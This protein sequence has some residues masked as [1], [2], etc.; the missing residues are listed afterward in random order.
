MNLETDD[1]LE[2]VREA[3]SGLRREIRT[4]FLPAQRDAAPPPA[5]P[6]TVAWDQTVADWARR[7]ATFGMRERSVEID[8][9]GMDEGALDALR[10]LLDFLFDRYWRVEVG[11]VAHLPGRGPCLLVANHSGVLPY[12]GVMI[13]HAVERASAGR[14]RARFTVAD[15]LVRLPFVQARLAR[16]GGVRA[17]RENVERLLAA[18]HFVTVFPEG[19]KG[20]AKLYHER[21]R[22]QRFGRGGV[23]RV[24]LA[25][26]VPLVPVAVVGAEEA[27][28][29]LYKVQT[30]A[31][32]LGLPFVPVTPTF[33]WLGPLGALPLPARWAIRFGEPIDFGDLPADAA[34]DDLLLSRLTEDVRRR[35]QALVDELR[36]AS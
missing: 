22:V 31:R 16:I 5:A 12:D 33:P 35:V 6:A 32:A 36:S 28:P 10:P 3:L 9:F 34:H 1:E 15:W 11:G 17:C 4:R 20:A 13:A 7:L 30:P 2:A 19:E 29:I 24:A 27:H 23:V 18:G 8:E 21:Y 25:S 26:G 14:V